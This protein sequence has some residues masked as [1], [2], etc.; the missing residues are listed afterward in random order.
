MGIP[1]SSFSI[2]LSGVVSSLCLPTACCAEQRAKEERQQTHGAPHLCL[3][4]VSALFSSC[5]RARVMDEEPIDV[6]ITEFAELLVRDYL[7]SRKLDQTLA[8]I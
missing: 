7:K 2:V 4:I 1:I 6:V 8:P 5:L 3:E